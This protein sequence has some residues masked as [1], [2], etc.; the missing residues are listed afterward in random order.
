MFSQPVVFQCRLRTNHA[1]YYQVQA[2]LFA[3]K[4]NYCDFV[5]WKEG[6]C[7]I[8]R[9]APD[10]QFTAD[11]VASVTEFFKL[12]VL[13]ELVGKW[14]TKSFTTLPE[15]SA[16]C[17]TCMQEKEGDIVECARTECS[18]RRYHIACLRLKQ[19]PKRKWYCPA[20]RKIRAAQQHGSKE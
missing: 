16:M 17:C 7:V 1:Y 20:C 8:I 15:Q 12:G 10:M 19:L 5:V 3:T 14:F 11:M 2:Q 4:A 9:I 6:E 18:I 13:P